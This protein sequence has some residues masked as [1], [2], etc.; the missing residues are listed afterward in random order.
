MPKFSV[1]RFTEE[2]CQHRHSIASY[3]VFGR[4]RLCFYFDRLVLEGAA[5][6]SALCCHQMIFWTMMKSETENITKVGLED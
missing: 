2:N 5:R 1:L 6:S 3:L 4:P